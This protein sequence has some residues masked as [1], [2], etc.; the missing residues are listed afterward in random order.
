MMNLTP[1]LLYPACK[2]YLWGGTRLREQYHKESEQQIIAESWELS[3]HPDG[4]SVIATGAHEGDTLRS[5]LAAH[6][7]A[8]GEKA[9]AFGQFPLLIKFIDA[10]G[11]LSIQVH[12]DDTYARRV[13]GAGQS[14]KTEMWY[15]LDCKAGAALYYGFEHPV[16]AQQVRAAVKDG[17][18][19]SLLHR[20]PVRPG[21]VFFIEAG[22]VHAIGAGMTLAEI[23]QNSNTTYRSMTLGGAGPTASRASC[24]LKKPWR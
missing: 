10:A 7:Q 3:C 18:I 11:D 14:G 4:E 21:D 15:I 6:P 8:A 9:A 2:D 24:T 13:E 1:F 20:V 5:F 19:T 23:Q 12:P 17:T 16:S 22:T